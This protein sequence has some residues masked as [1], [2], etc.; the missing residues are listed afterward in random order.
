MT[1]VLAYEPH[2]AQSL[3][4]AGGEPGGGGGGGGGGKP[5][6][7]GGSLGFKGCFDIYSAGSVG[8]DSVDFVDGTSSVVT[9]SRADLV[10][11]LDAIPTAPRAIAAISFSS[12]N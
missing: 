3:V 10:F 11:V 4:P 6:A 7:G 9:A 12:R 8:K 1:G 5:L 2:T